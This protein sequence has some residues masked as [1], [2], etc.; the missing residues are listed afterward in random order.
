KSQVLEDIQAN[1]GDSKHIKRSLTRGIAHRVWTQCAA[2]AILGKDAFGGG[3]LGQ[4]LMHAGIPFE[5]AYQGINR[6]TDVLGGSVVPELAKPYEAEDGKNKDHAGGIGHIAAK[7]ADHLARGI[8]DPLTAATVSRGISS[9]VHKA[10]GTGHADGFL[11]NW[12]S[13]LN[14]GGD[15]NN[16]ELIDELSYYGGLDAGIHTANALGLKKTWSGAVLASAIAAGCYTSR[17]PANSLMD[18]NTPSQLSKKFIARTIQRLGVMGQIYALPLPI[19]DNYFPESEDK[20]DKAKEAAAIE[21]TPDEIA[22][23]KKITAA[24]RASEILYGLTTFA[25]LSGLYAY[26]NKKA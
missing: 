19:L 9:V 1:G 20:A 8:I 21:K 4:N 25:A 18:A 22:K 23:D 2:F 3:T 14:K 15:H 16:G 11:A 17:D 7:T 5:I 26:Q 13:E 24:S 6:G 10:A 12:N